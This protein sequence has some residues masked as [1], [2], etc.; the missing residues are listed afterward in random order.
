M[1]QKFKATLTGN[2]IQWLDDIP[3]SLTKKSTTVYII[4]TEPESTVDGITNE[5][6]L[7][8]LKE[9]E[10]GSSEVF[11]NVDELFKDLDN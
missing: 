9:I 5:T 2:Q 6:T 8:A 1:L 4:F 3:A 10:S 7:N 11:K